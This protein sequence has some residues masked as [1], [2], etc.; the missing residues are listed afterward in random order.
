MKAT[1]LPRKPEYFILNRHCNT[2]LYNEVNLLRLSVISYF[3][4]LL[5]FCHINICIVKQTYFD[6]SVCSLDTC[7]ID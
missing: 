1:G 7:E 2:S 5:F 4:N 6:L 3:S